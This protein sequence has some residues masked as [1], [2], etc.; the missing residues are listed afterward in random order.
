[1]L[2]LQPSALERAFQ[3]VAQQGGEVPGGIL[4]DIVG[5]A[6]A[7]G[8]DGDTAFLG[9]GDIDHRRRVRQGDDVVQDVETVAA[10][11]VV[12]EGHDVEIVGS[13]DERAQAG[14]AVGRTGHGIA[15]SPQ[16]LLDQP[17]Q[18]AVII[19]VEQADEVARSLHLVNSLDVRGL[20]DRE[21]EP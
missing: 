10:G 13:G 17:R 5:G 16:L 9:P 7:E 6:G 8:G 4:D 3:R 1:M 21:K 15:V 2:A 20:H 18:P 12:I 14:V 11:H 19:D